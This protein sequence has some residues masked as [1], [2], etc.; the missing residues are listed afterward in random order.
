LKSRKGEWK[1]KRKIGETTVQAHE[2]IEEGKDSM[3]K[4]G[5]GRKIMGVAGGRGTLEA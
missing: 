5:K 4:G 3:W 2:G 1:I